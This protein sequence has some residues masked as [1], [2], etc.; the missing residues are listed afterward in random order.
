MKVVTSPAE[1]QAEALQ[2]RRAGKTIAFVPTMGYLHEGHLSLVRLARARGDVLVVSIFVNPTQ[3]APTEDFG[4]YPR[5]LDR[6]LAL[7][8]EEGA[9]IAF[10]PS[11]NDMYASDHSVYVLEETL[12]KGLCGRSRP[13]FFRGV[14]T[15]VGKLFNIVQPDVAVFG[16]K[17]A[18]QARVIQRLV[19]DMSFPVEILVG[20]IVRDKDGLAMSSRNMYLTPA[21]RTHALCLPRCLELAR[22]MYDEGVRD[23]S[24]IRE[25][26]MALLSETKGVEIDYVELVDWETLAPQETITGT[27]L[28]A[29]AIRIGE[30]R[31]ID[32]VLI[33]LS[34]DQP[35]P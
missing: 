29:G 33:G 23:V 11:D 34:A 8:R 25:K 9:D 26:A 30:T 12:S 14:A 16:Q 13:G 17:D 5:D 3:F 22:R 20:P 21:Q 32:N 24:L 35:F 18:Q 2:L 7:C 10:C 27:S 15:V 31:L 4:T 1:M 19:R 28:V 6:D